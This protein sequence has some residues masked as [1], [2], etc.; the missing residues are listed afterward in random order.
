MQTPMADHKHM[1][2]LTGGYI[3]YVIVLELTEGNA[4]DMII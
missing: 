4:H 2:E 1:H 3:Y